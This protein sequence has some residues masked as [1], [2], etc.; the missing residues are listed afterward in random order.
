MYFFLFHHEIVCVYSLNRLT[1]A[2]LMNILT[3]LVLRIEKKIPN[4]STFASW[5]GAMINLQWLEL[6]ISRTHFHGSKDV[7]AIEVRL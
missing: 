2:I 1:E 3:I 4:L 6:P 5:Y 7:R